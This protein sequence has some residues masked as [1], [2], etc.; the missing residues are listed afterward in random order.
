MNA[1]R[2]FMLAGL[3]ALT[4]TL[5]MPPPTL[6]AASDAAAQASKKS[7]QQWRDA[8]RKFE[9]VAAPLQ[10]DPAKGKLVVPFLASLDDT[11]AALTQALDAQASGT[12]PDKV[13]KAMEQLRDKL[14]VLAAQQARLKSD[15]QLSGASANLMNVLGGV[16]STQQQTT[17]STVKNL[18]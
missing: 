8:R 6:A 16:L 2:S 10:A 13:G 7:L 3:V 12:D 14:G 4:G 5:M 17:K 11:E 9:A 1:F 18:R 15:K